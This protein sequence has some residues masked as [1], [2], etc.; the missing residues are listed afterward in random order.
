MLPLWNV[1]DR[2][3]DTLRA[4]AATL[5]F[6]NA[7]WKPPGENGRNYRAWASTSQAARAE[8]LG[9][10]KPRRLEWRSYVVEFEAAKYP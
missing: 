9:R 1:R 2:R 8:V 4:A 5:M 6:A 10:S 3:H 7:T